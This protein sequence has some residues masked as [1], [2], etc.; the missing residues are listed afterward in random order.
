LRADQLAKKGGQ[1]EQDDSEVTFLEKKRA[2]QAVKREQHHMSDD[3]HLL[4][5]QGQVIILH[6]RTGHNRLNYHMFKLRLSASPF[7]TC[8]PH[9]QTAVHVLQDCPLNDEL[10][11]Y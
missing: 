10:R 11:K 5:R 1:C 9:N 7:C 6:F 2:I 3:Y 4:D 8:G